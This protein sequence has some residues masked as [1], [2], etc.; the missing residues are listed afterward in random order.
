MVWDPV[1]PRLHDAARVYVVPVGAIHLVIFAALPTGRD[2]YLV[3]QGAAFH[4]L[5]AERDLVPRAG[6]VAGGSGLL[7]LGEPAFDVA[8]AA[9]PGD[10]GA[11]APG[12]A[13]S[14]CA[15]FRALRFQPLP[16]TGREAR[17]VAAIWGTRS[18]AMVLLGA[19]AT[20][21]AFKAH[22]PGRSVVHL[23]THGFFL[24]DVTRPD[25]RVVRRGIGAIG[26]GGA[27]VTE[28][29]PCAANPLLLSGLAFAG[30][31]QRAS[32]RSSQED[33]ILTAEEV[34][35]INLTGVDWVVLSA[36]DTGKGR[37]QAGEGV[38]GL[39]RAFQIAGAR[40]VIMSLWAVEDESAR[41]WMDALYRARISE[42]LDAA[43]AAAKA[44]LSVLRWRRAQ[45]RGTDPF[46]WAAFVAT[47][48]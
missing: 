34:S 8:A 7:V 27:P 35:A 47:G 31:N 13:A 4:Y 16:G 32:A 14:G 44:D 29:R 21:A 38:L 17:D 39:R 30:A 42:G 24:G 5:S 12:P 41:Q 10:S 1:A 23:A 46:Y 25:P 6:H 37:I 45:A 43:D 9:G 2:R 28:S 18:P 36:C 33:G 48:D 22:A 15:S 26:S 19:A 40:A 20:E 3:E 11:V